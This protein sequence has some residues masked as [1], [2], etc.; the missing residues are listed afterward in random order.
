VFVNFLWNR[1]VWLALLGGAI[2]CFAFL[3]QKPFLLW[4]AFGFLSLAFLFGPLQWI[5]DWATDAYI[6]GGSS[7]MRHD[8]DVARF[9]A[10]YF[11]YLLTARIVVAGI[12]CV[13][14]AVGVG[15]ATGW[16]S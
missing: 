6:S 4:F 16:I 7:G 11:P 5:D 1:P 13:L 15:K 10:S 12:A 8:T 9:Q 14:I 3:D 2:T